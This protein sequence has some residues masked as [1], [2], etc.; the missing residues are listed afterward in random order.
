MNSAKKK[1]IYFNLFFLLIFLFFPL[2]AFSLEENPN[3]IQSMTAT[4]TLSGEGKILG[5]TDSRDEIEL[6]MISFQEFQGIEILSLEEKLTIEGQEFEAEHEE[7]DGARY[8]VFNLKNLKQFGNNP[9]FEVSVK[10]KI[11]S[12]AEIGL[13]ESNAEL[14]KSVSEKFLEA[15]D[16]IESDDP[17]LIAKANMEFESRNKL[18]TLIEIS[19]WIGNN[20]EYDLAY[21][22]VINSAK[23]TYQLRKGVC[24]EFANLT[25][26]FARIKKIPIKYVSG[27]SFDGKKF[28]SHGW[29]EAFIEG[30]GW[31]AIDSTYNEVGFVDGAHFPLTKGKDANEFGSME[32]SIKSVNSL[33]ME[34]KINEP[35]VEVHSFEEFKELAEM[36][37]ELPEKIFNKEEFEVNAKITSTTGKKMIYPIKLLLHEDFYFNEEN[38]M[39]LLE[40][41]ESIQAKWTAIAPLKGEEGKYFTYEVKIISPDHKIEKEIE[42][43]PNEETEEKAGEIKV[44]DISPF[45]EGNSL[46]IR[47][48][49]ENTG[50]AENTA[51]IWM[52]F[53]KEKQL[54]QEITFQALEQKEFELILSPFEFGN[55]ELFIESNETQIKKTIFV[56]KKQEP[57]VAI[58]PQENQAQPQTDSNQENE[59]TKTAFIESIIKAVMGFLK[60]IGFIQ[61]Q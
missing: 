48:S 5:E 39:L 58:Q 22:P 12:N 31:I 56:P 40:P 61:T 49:L 18:E 11:K 30:Y 17:E 14:E 44:M 2:N 59:E 26:A 35:L 16:L 51:L 21:Y 41:N 3:S 52:E 34:M 55:I 29:N 20:L 9:E 50:L 42:I 23:K 10:A 24:D 45:K 8:A 15:T 27:I 37:I 43:Y 60:S 1:L 47:I 32:S 4:I 36:E 7:K 13:S 38:K 54:E 25:A 6:R 33:G 46:K 19:K 53:K 28:G 57:V